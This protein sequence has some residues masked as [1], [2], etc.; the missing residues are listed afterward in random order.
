MIFGYLFAPIAWIIGIP[1]EDI[2]LAGQLLGEKTIANEFVAYKSLGNLINNNSINEKTAIMA[3][4]FLCG[5]AN[6]LSIGIQIGGIGS[7]A[8][9]RQE[10][11]SKLGLR[12]LLAATLATL[13][14]GNIA[15][16][17]IA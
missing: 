3:T 2:L 13:L 16:Y 4:Y 1:L 17:I 12:A 5:F 11:I 9:S 7:M 15:G 10:D 6:F 14:T 8:P